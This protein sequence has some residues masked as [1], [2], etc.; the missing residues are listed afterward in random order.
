MKRT[1]TDD[2]NLSLLRSS[3]QKLFQFNYL[4]CTVVSSDV[5]PQGGV[6]VV[7]VVCAFVYLKST[8]A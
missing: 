3:L 8:A 4:A 5:I 7:A 2:A 1:D 6:T